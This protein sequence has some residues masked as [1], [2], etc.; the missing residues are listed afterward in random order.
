[1]TDPNPGEHVAP[2]S[3]DLE[4]LERVVRVLAYTLYQQTGDHAEAEKVLV[5]ELAASGGDV[6]PFA[7]AMAWLVATVAEQ[8][9]DE[10][11]AWLES[12]I[13]AAMAD[14]MTHQP[15]T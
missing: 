10:L 11:T 15:P 1:M 5:D 4:A 2:V 8:Q 6:A 9:P 7:R 13:G 12:T 3:M 14:L